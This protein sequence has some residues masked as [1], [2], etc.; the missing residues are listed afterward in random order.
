MSN[1]EDSVIPE[2]PKVFI[3]FY[4]SMFYLLLTQWNLILSYLYY[5]SRED[6]K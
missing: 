2:T 1:N 6:I 3:P 4:Y 5:F